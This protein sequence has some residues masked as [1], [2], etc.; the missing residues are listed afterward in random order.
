MR[1]EVG[2]KH[3]YGP[4]K[5]GRDLREQLNPLAS[6]R[7]FQAAEAC[8]V[9]TRAVELR[10]DAA[11]DGIDH[12]REDDRDRPRRPLG[13]SGCRGPVCHD[14]VGLQADQLLRERSY[15]IVVTAAP[16]KVHPHVAAIDPT[17]VR[18]RLSERR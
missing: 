5:P 8:G 13:G 16:P 6:Q 18:K 2:V 17:Q 14:D 10:D 11:C 1:G 12:V 3:D 15:P 9:S 4:L 7:G